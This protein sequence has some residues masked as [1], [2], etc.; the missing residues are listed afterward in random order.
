MVTTLR[1][2]AVEDDTDDQLL[3]EEAIRAF[4]QHI[5]VEFFSEAGLLLARVASPLDHWPDLMLI[6]AHLPRVSGFELISQLRQLE[7]GRRI[8]LVVL[9]GRAGPDTIRLAETAGASG[10]LIKPATTAEFDQLISLFVETW[11]RSEKKPETFVC[12]SC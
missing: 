6:D 9:T 7:Q 1:V 5:E 4:D 12:L 3:L 11:L 2:W 8:P 10:L